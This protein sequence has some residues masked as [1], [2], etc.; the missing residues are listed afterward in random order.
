MVI[1][2]NYLLEYVLENKDKSFKEYPFNEI[3]AAIYS[4]ISYL[5]LKDITKPIS[6]KE[7]YKSHFKRFKDKNKIKFYQT[8]NELFIEMANSIRYQDNLLSNFKTILNK[9][10][11]FGAI[12]ITVPHY[13]KY[14]SFEGTDDNLSGWKED[15]ELSYD[16]P[17]RAQKEAINYLKENIKFNDT[18]VF[19][20]GHSKGGNLAITSLMEANAINRLKVQYV[21]NFDGPGFMPNI[22]NSK[23]YQRIVKKI[24]NY[25]PEDSIVG[26]MMDNGGVKK[27]VKS[28]TKL[29]NN[30][31]PHTW[32]WED[33]HFVYGKLSKSALAFHKKVNNYLQMDSGKRKK[34]NEMLFKLLYSAGY[35]KY[36][37]ISKLNFS[38]FKNIIKTTLRLKDEEKELLFEAFKLLI[39]KPID[40]SNIKN[41]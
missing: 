7:F 13:F 30:H 35:S 41:N 12:T 22:Y 33:N 32:K 9:N 11:Q 17:I 15:F 3:D 40:S 5:D 27:V 38:R 18:L 14:I 10:T 24:R 1:V 8:N 4:L 39:M 16:Y 20:G 26:M 23:K 34:I 29:I 2:V 25:Y 6:I 36:S 28:S 19:I 31:Y 37:E 21:F